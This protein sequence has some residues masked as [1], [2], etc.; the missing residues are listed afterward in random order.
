MPSLSTSTRISRTP[1]STGVESAKVKSYT[2]YNHTLLATEFKSVV[3]D[4]H[5]LK[6]H[7]QIWDVSCQK[8]IR[9][10]GKDAEKLMRL[11]SP[12][13]L[14]KMSLDQCYYVP[15]IDKKGGLL[16]DP[17]VLKITPFEYWISIADSDFL[18][19]ILGIS[20]ALCFDTQIDLPTIYPVA[21]QG[22]K[23][24]K[25]MV[26]VFGEEI[27]DIKFFRYKKIS[28][29]ESKLLI[30]RS[31]WSKQGGFEIYLN[32]PE[33]GM[34]LWNNL[35]S[36]GEEFN[37]RVGCPNL[38]ERIEGGLLSYG[39]DMS[40]E[41]TP[42][43]AGLGKYVNSRDN[44]IGKENLLVRPFKKIIKPIEILGDIPVCDRPWPI[45]AKG[46]SIG[47]VTSAALSPDLEIN[48]AI[49]MVDKVLGKPN[50]TVEVETQTGIRTAIIHSNF[51]T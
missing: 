41:N 39:N 15:F 22:P 40:Q 29:L 20:D 17:I 13:D 6:G 50:S 43:E 24:E 45:F 19:Y 21:I 48:V 35:I 14:T 49:G 34:L 46:K 30:A 9:V 27:S 33:I 23:S 16:N 36:A 38:I 26:K 18:L 44:F 1:F 51:W 32:Q 11:I 7:V 25:L 42:F 2:V 37:V 8:Q 12:R 31:G 47:Q 3:D 10:R 5:H 4:Y 28:Y